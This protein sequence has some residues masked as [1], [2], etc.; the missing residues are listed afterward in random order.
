MTQAV[1]KAVESMPMFTNSPKTDPAIDAKHSWIQDD[2]V[3]NS[4]YREKQHSCLSLPKS[5]KKLT[6][7]RNH[8][9]KKLRLSQVLDKRFDQ[10]RWFC[11]ADKNISNADNRFRSRNVASNFHNPGDFLDK[12]RHNSCIIKN[13]DDHWEVNDGW[14][15]GKSKWGNVA[16][17]I[18]KNSER[19]AFRI[20]EELLNLVGKPVK[21]EK[22][23]GSSQNENAEDDLDA[24]SPND[25]PKIDFVRRTWQENADE[26]VN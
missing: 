4:F 15:G 20:V 25:C 24:K 3:S 5:F 16:F 2:T 26:G 17:W 14:K 6:K 18:A 13:G 7:S 22:T 23:G 21:S 11:L 10:K 19:T 1:S 8:N 9:N 12:I